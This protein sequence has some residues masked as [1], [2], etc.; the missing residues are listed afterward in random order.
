MGVAMGLGQELVKG[1]VLQAQLRGINHICESAAV[2]G[3]V[4]SRCLHSVY[5]LYVMFAFLLS[6][7]HGCWKYMIYY[8]YT[9]SDQASGAC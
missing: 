6:H 4:K 2:S 3:W 9:S 7:K 1:W 8:I 5:L